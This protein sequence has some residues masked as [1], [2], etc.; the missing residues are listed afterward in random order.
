MGC[1][2]PSLRPALSSSDRP[3]LPQDVSDC[4]L[5]LF[6]SHLYFQAHGSEGLTFQVRDIRRGGKPPGEAG[7]LPPGAP[8]QPS[9]VLWQGL[10][11][12][13]ELSIGSLEGSAEPAFQITGVWDTGRTVSMLRGPA[14]SSAGT[15][16]RARLRGGQRIRGLQNCT[17][18]LVTGSGPG[19]RHR[20]LP[21]L[22]P[23]AVRSLGRGLSRG[24]PVQPTLSS[25]H[26][27]AAGPSAGAL[28]QPG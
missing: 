11:P 8:A 27:P 14:F 17:C 10:L 16:A 7:P 26:R 9:P 23:G 20:L 22:F 25:T 6:P 24:P 2:G 5:E 3:L 18:G 4:Y 19:L 13:M 15:R 28:P 12:L 21:S 1:S